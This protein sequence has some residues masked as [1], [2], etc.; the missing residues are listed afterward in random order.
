MTLAKMKEASGKVVEMV[1]T[2]HL[3]DA[4]NPVKEAHAMFLFV[5]SIATIIMCCASTTV[6]VRAA[7]DSN[8]AMNA[9]NIRRKYQRNMQLYMIV[10]E[11]KMIDKQLAKAASGQYSANSM[12]NS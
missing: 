3:S 7:R 10:K 4:S 9:F 12:N 8:I 11:K 2:V 5:F 6:C 1:T